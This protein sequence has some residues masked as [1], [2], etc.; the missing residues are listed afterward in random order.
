MTD[1]ANAFLDQDLSDLDFSQLK[2]VQFEFQA[3]T[4][5]VNRRLPAEL[6]KAVRKKA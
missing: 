2:P 6:L 3:K 4:E 5:Y 1:D